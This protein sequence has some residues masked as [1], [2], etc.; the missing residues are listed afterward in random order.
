MIVLE[1]E[2]GPGVVSY[3]YL[4]PAIV[5][6]V[7]KDHAHPFGLRSADS[8]FFA[9]VSERAVVIVV[10]EGGLLPAIVIGVAIGPVAW[11]VFSAPEVVFGGPIDVIR[12]DE[13]EPT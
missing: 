1:K 9:H 10:I 2:I 12:D 6:Q 8:G 3:G 7:C 11:F 13:I 5:V 4:G